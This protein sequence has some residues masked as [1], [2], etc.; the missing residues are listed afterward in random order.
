MKKSIKIVQF[1]NPILEQS[2]EPVT[3]PISISEEKVINKII[4]YLTKNPESAAGLAAP[5]I[6]VSKKICG[7]RRLDLENR[8]TNFDILLMINPSIIWTSNELSTEWEG[9]LSINYG[10]L[11]GQV[12]RPERVTVKYYDQTGVEHE[13][14]F[15]GYQSH[16]V[17]HEI[18]HLNGIL[19]LKYVTDPSELYTTEELKEILQ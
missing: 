7:V 9:C 13:E 15:S 5:Q 19:F 10:D 18:D 16:I 17:Q 4:T 14:T 1:G 11:W 8:E 12:T 3:F 6:G 2:S